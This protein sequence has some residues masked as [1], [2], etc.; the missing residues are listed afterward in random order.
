MVNLNIKELIFLNQ[1]V[2]G[3]VTKGQILEWLSAYD[4]ETKQ[5]ILREVWVLAVQANTVEEDID[6]AVKRAGLKLTHTPTR[7]LYKS[8]IPFRNRGYSLSDL[9]GKELLQALQLVIECF[10]IA[11]NRRRLTCSPERCNHWWHQDLSNPKIVE[12]ILERGY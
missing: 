10:A 4:E 11:E 6:E 8:G 12:K 1:Y 9:K 7:M 5:N 2:Q 3:I